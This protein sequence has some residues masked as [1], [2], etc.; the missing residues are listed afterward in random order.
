MECQAGV[1]RAAGAGGVLSRGLAF[2]AALTLAGCVTLGG[3]AKPATIEYR[4]AACP[5]TPI[6]KPQ[7]FRPPPPGTIRNQVDVFANELR[8]FVVTEAW[9]AG[10]DGC[11]AIGNGA[12]RPTPFP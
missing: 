3:G 6:V 1:S 8:C 11:S 5:E 4:T 2:A 12:G 10:Y 7:C 9:R